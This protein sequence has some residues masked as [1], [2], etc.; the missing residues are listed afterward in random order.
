MRW[1]P[2]IPLRRHFPLFFPK[3]IKARVNVTLSYSFDLTW[4]FEMW[5]APHMCGSSWLV[6]GLENWKRIMKLAGWT[7]ALDSD[8]SEFISWRCR[9][10]ATWPWAWFLSFLGLSFPVGMM[11]VHNACLLGFLSGLKDTERPAQ[12][13]AYD[14]S[15]GKQSLLPIFREHSPSLPSSKQNWLTKVWW[16][17]VVWCLEGSDLSV[18]EEWVPGGL[19][20]D[21]EVG[22]YWGAWVPIS[23]DRR[24]LLT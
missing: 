14:G 21:D 18:A 10:P 13:L 6:S 24:E 2:T 16:R 15:L 8:I 22:G 20:R 12:S 17:L 3:K 9:F 7:Q 1:F 19:C 4:L 11:K 5:E 23:L